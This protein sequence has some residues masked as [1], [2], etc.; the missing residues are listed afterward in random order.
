MPGLKINQSNICTSFTLCH[1]KDFPPTGS[2]TEGPTNRDDQL[3]A[4]YNK[5]GG[6]VGGVG[7]TPF[8]NDS[9]L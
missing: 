1:S 9:A 3:S 2:K 8:H 5:G 6:V 7:C 4:I